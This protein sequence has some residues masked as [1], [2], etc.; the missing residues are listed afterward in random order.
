MSGD[1]KP[2][3]RYPGSMGC[4]LPILAC[5]LFWVLLILSIKWLLGVV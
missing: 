5:L 1:D 2:Y 4:L 3:T